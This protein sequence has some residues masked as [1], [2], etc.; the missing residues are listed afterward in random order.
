MYDQDLTIGFD[1]EVVFVNI[2]KVIWLE[3]N[4][5]RVLQDESLIRAAQLGQAGAQGTIEASQ[6]KIQLIFDQPE[7]VSFTAKDSI[8]IEVQEALF[9]DEALSSNIL[10]EDLFVD[11]EKSSYSANHPIQSPYSEDLI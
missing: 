1:W 11:Q 9:A 6:I 4:Q 8:Q 10:V 7:I 2:T 5:T 3:N